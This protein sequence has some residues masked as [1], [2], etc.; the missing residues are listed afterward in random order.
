MIGVLAPAFTKRV[1]SRVGDRFVWWVGYAIVVGGGL[2]IAAVARRRVTEPWLGLSL[3]LILL[4]LLGWM[5]RPRTSL[6]ATLFLAAVSDLATVSW[7]PFVK[8]LS[9]R[10]S[11]SFV[12]DALTISPLDITLAAGA[13]ISLLRHYATSGKWLPRTAMTWPIVAF[14]A[15]VMYGYVRG[16][17]MR[18]G[19]AR[20]AVLEG[21]AL[22]YIAMVFVIATVECSEHRHFRHGFYAIVA[23]VTVQS[24][25]SIQYL[26]GLDPAARDDLERLNEHGSSLGHN[27]LIVMMLCLVL[28]RVK[29]PLLKWALVGG[30]VPTI[31]VFFVAQRRAGVASL[32]IAGLVL[33]IALFWR[34]R[35]VFW[36]TIPILSIVLIGYVGAFWN[37][38]A[39]VAFPAQA[40]KTIVAPDSASAADQSSDL[41]RLIEAYNLNFTIRTSPL[42]GLGFGQA[43]YRPVALAD[44]SSFE[45]NAYLPHN[46]ILWVWIK[47]GFGG[48]VAMFYMLGKAIMLGADQVRRRTEGIDLVVALTATMFI[49]MYTTYTYV[50]VSW[51][52]RN[53][54]FLAFAF[55]TVAHGVPARRTRRRDATDV[56]PDVLEADH[57][58]MLQ[59]VAR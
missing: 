2:M 14:T 15:F 44:I 6:Y 21:R 55:A 57:G 34:R 28:L 23:G 11:I 40:I 47:M 31:F 22:F 4:L 18:G 17:L 1:G 12:A 58:T 52:A 42:F 50:D 33:A 13:A 29:R 56:E 27:L 59:P 48:F 39:A 38:S 26:N 51:D 35:R 16:V 8:N 9:S 25:L 41:Y 46:S 7:F 24:L 49:V 37:S 19:D 43:F 5:I 54:V 10:E 20:V 36:T 45:L 32:V 53:T 30:A 3:A